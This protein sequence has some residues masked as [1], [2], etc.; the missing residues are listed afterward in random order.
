[1]ALYLSGDYTANAVD[2]VMEAFAKHPKKIMK[3][4]FGDWNIPETHRK[5]FLK[6]VNQWGMS[7]V[8]TSHLAEGFKM[9]DWHTQRSRKVI[10]DKKGNLKYIA[11]SFP[12]LKSINLKGHIATLQEWQSLNTLT[13]FD[14]LY[15]ESAQSGDALNKS[16]VLNKLENLIIKQTPSSPLKI[17]TNITSLRVHLDNTS[18]VDYIDCSVGGPENL[19]ITGKGIFN[20]ADLKGATNLKSLI[21]D[22]GIQVQGHFPELVNLRKLQIADHTDNNALKSLANLA[23][24]EI[25]SVN[26]LALDSETFKKWANLKNLRVLNL[27]SANLDD[28]DMKVLT[29]LAKLKALEL[30]ASERI[31]TKT[32]EVLYKIPKLERVKFIGTS[33]YSEDLKKEYSPLGSWDYEM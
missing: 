5:K 18:L 27:T 23:H 30:P 3:V 33:I 11:R 4:S 6:R 10:H 19:K 31:T 25:I 24:L 20:P 29:S 13:R 22:Q 26:C 28:E 15:L 7:V 17:P 14:S 8:Y 12:M 1:M 2:L 16:G 9:P 32:L 21:I